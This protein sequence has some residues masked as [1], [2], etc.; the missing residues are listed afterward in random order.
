MR[1]KEANHFKDNMNSF[2]LNFLKANLVESIVPT[3]RERYKGKR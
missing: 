3:H 2:S 1:T